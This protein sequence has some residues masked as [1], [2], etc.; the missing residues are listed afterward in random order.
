MFLLL[1]LSVNLWT[2]LTKFKWLKKTNG[3]EKQVTEPAQ[4][5]GDCCAA[6]VC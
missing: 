5:A 3:Y 2:D 6:R 1:A 4:S